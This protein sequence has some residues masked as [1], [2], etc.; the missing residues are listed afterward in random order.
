MDERNRCSEPVPKAVRME[1]AAARVP[2][3]AWRTGYPVRAAASL[4]AKRGSDAAV[5]GAQVLTAPGFPRSK[6]EC[7]PDYGVKKRTQR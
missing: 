6:H 3:E 7:R 2:G 4:H 1:F 5:I